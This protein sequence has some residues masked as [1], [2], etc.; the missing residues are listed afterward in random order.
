[1]YRTGDLVRWRADGGL[2]FL[3]RADHQVKLRGYRIE[4]GE[5]EAA[6]DAQTGVRQ[7]V[8]MAREDVPGLVQLVAYLTVNQ[9]VTEAALQ[10]ALS[11]VLPAHMVPSRFM[12]LD[13]FP[14]TPNKKVD[15]KALPAPAARQS[16]AVPMSDLTTGPTGGSTEV[17]IAAIWSRL[18]GVTTITSRDSFFELGGHSLLA[19]Q[20]HR[21]IRDTLKAPHLSITDIF[22]YP[23][24]GALAAKLDEGKA[25]VMADEPADDR[26]A[27][28]TDA[29]SRRRDMR[30]R[31]Q[32]TP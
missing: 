9:P 22:R 31:R 26:A 25:P 18:L 23:T 8:V 1:M 15:R 11:H 4:L 12:T 14:L 5:I 13:S 29:M 10:A 3:G 6:L 17:Q 21:D 7:A 30:A 19:V 27:A 2:D 16:G 28:R 20:A 32:G 24:L